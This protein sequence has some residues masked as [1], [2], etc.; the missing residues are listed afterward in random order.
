MCNYLLPGGKYCG[1]QRARCKSKDNTKCRI[2]KYIKHEQHP[3]IR[4][5]HCDWYIARYLPGSPGQ[6]R[7]KAHV[8]TRHPYEYIKIQQFINPLT[9]VIYT[10]G[11]R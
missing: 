5:Q 4:C 10:E 8:M 7:L 6:D 3:L 2:I 11:N 1:L 9:A